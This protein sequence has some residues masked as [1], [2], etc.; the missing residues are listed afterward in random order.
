M[1]I[2]VVGMCPSNKPTLGKTRNATF[3]RLESWMDSLGVHHF[4]FSN[5]FDYPAPPTLSK[6]DYKRLC[7]LTKDYDKIIALGGFV[8]L[9]LNRLNVKH[10]TLPHPSPL[11]RLLND[12]MYENKIISECKDYLNDR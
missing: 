7:T 3:K 4:S 1:K 9:A 12:K 11:N 8:S 5:T 10:F 6:V 2:L